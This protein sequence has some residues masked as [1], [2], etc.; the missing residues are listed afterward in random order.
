MT[1]AF[2]SSKDPS[3]KLPLTFDFTAWTSDALSNPTITITWHSGPKGALDLS[4]MLLGAA[5]ISGQA[6]IQKVQG[7]VVGTTYK[8]RCQ[9]DTAGNDRYVLA[10]LLP[11]ETA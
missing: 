8:V 10:G 11:V 5:Q 6:V 9:V 1:D 4:G 2:D 7:G 3:E